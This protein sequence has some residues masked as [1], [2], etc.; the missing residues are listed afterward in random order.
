MKFLGKIFVAYVRMEI[1]KYMLWF[2]INTVPYTITFI[3]KW[4]FTKA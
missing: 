2:L 1:I 4:G 3:I